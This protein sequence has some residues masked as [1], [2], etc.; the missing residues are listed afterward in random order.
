MAS[1]LGMARDIEAMYFDRNLYG[2]HPLCV[3][4]S[5]TTHRAHA[6]FLRN[7]N[8]MDVVYHQDNKLE[9]RVG[10]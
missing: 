7:S 9:F 8:G 10:H 2:S 1:V 6:V 3:S 5:P 4:V